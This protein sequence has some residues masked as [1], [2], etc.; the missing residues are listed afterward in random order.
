[1]VADI[2]EAKVLS[3]AKSN[4][5]TNVLRSEILWQKKKETTSPSK[6]LDFVAVTCKRKTFAV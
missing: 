5:P 1:M 6:P 3:M 4:T 2:S